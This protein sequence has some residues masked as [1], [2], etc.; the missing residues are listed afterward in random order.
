MSTCY[1]QTLSWSWST[2]TYTR[3]NK[4]MQI[5]SVKYGG[6]RKVYITERRRNVDWMTL[7]GDWM[8]TEMYCNSVVTGDWKFT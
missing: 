8:V 3:N 1:I 7:N 2:I 5:R 6:K 4:I